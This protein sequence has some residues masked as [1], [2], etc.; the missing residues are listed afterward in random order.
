MLRRRSF[1]YLVDGLTEDKA[2]IL[3]QSLAI[4]PQ[5]LA[6]DVSVGRSM[7]EV[8]ARRDV[9]D[10]VRLACSVAGAYYRTRAGVSSR[11]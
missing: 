3:R 10:Q 9:A 8:T 2:E 4:V 11:P 6:V 5:I 1:H 7:I